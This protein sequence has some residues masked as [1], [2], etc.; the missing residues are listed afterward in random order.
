MQ[1]LW[2]EGGTKEEK[3]KESRERERE[4]EG[5]NNEKFVLGCIEAMCGAI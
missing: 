2:S 1:Q 4:I 5:E 3:T